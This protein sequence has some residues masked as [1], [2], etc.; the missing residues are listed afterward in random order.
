MPH[1]LLA[2]IKI[3]YAFALIVLAGI[4]LGSF[5][6]F[7]IYETHEKTTANEINTS[8]RQRM[9]SQRLALLG[10]QM[11]RLEESKKRQDIRIE[12]QNLI[13]IFKKNHKALTLG[14]PALEISPPRSD[15][16]KNIYFGP[17]VNL[18]ILVKNL[19][20]NAEYLLREHD[21]QSPSSLDDINHDHVQRFLALSNT[22]FLSALDTAVTQYQHDAEKRLGNFHIYSIILLVI[23]LMLIGFSWIGIFRPLSQKLSNY[24]EQITTIAND[25]DA[26]KKEA[27]HANQV[28]VNFLSNMSHEL[29]TPLNSILGFSQLLQTNK[30]TLLTQQQSE[31]VIQ[32]KMAGDHL[33]NIVDDILDFS[34]VEAGKFHIDIHPI[35]PQEI[36]TE[37]LTYTSNAA[38]QKN[39]SL[40]IEE[41]GPFPVIMADATRLRQITLNV[42]SNAIKYNRP[43]GKVILSTELFNKH[44]R[45]SIRDTGFGIPKE[46]QNEIFQPFNRLGAE[47]SN[48]KG[49][50]IGLVITKKLLEKMDGNIGFES[51]PDMGSTFWFDLPLQSLSRNSSSQ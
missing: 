45:V 1:S 20:N 32:I 10:L 42:I 37:C 41:S 47:T 38:Q 7:Q 15:A 35:S 28:K 19:I 3:K 13:E 30:E 50:G 17:A 34:K 29:H 26:A 4:S 23:S 22:T 33:L 16:I 51:V 12:F 39:I 5:L 43:D 49:N 27:E 21:A 46:K 6:L 40:K 31:Q 8:G 24:I 36:F 25:L 9:I 18:D 11:D 2:V 48:V 14:D 44:L